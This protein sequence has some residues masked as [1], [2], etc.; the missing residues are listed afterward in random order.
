MANKMRIKKGSGSVAQSIKSMTLPM[1]LAFIIPLA[2]A[3]VLAAFLIYLIYTGDSITPRR[4]ALEAFLV[5]DGKWSNI[6]AYK[7]DVW[8]PS[9]IEEEEVDASVRDSQRLF[10]TRDKGKFP[11][12][13]YGVIVVTDEQLDG[14]TFDIENDPSSVL[15]IVTPILTEA[16][17]KMINGVYPTLTIDVSVDTLQSGRPVLV[18]SGEASVILALRDPK[19]PDNP[20]TEEATTNIYYNVV[21]HSGRPVIVWG[22][23]DYSTYEGEL[24]TKQSVVDGVTSLLDEEEVWVSVDVSEAFNTYVTPQVNSE[25][26]DGYN[27]SDQESTQSAGDLSDIEDINSPD[28]A[29]STHTLNER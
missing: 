21:D 10:V 7:L 9:D 17:G 12:I 27:D 24:R 11:E 23:W 26:L 18:G 2:V 22:T 8:C 19:D 20:Y 4:E 6:D 14:R 29:E 25:G 1:K 28:L 3:M 5:S 13:A 15:D 16:F